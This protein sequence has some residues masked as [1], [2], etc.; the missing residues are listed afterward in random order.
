M[1]STPLLIKAGKTAYE[2]DRWGDYSG[3]GID[4]SDATVWIAGEL[5]RDPTNWGTHIAEIGF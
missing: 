3:A 5:T 2:K 1:F 4:S